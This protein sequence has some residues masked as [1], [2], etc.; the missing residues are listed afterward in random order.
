MPG[1]LYIY[2]DA[3]G[4]AYMREFMHVEDQP[5]AAGGSGGADRGAYPWNGPNIRAGLSKYAKLT[6]G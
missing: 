4:T 6:K 1:P 2:H 3:K 5:A